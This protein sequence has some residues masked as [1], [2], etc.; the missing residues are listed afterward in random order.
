MI[1][2]GIKEGPSMEVNIGNSITQ[3]RENYAGR[4]LIVKR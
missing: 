3:G 2:R 4:E 1:F